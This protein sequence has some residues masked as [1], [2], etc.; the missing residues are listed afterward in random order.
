MEIKRIK[1]QINFYSINDIKF[2]LIRDQFISKKTYNEI[3]K[4]MFKSKN[5]KINSV[6]KKLFLNKKDLKKLLNDGHEIGLH[7]HSHPTKISHLSFKKQFKEYKIN[8][9]YL[10][11]KIDKN[12]NKVISMSHPCGDYNTNTLKILKKME[13]EIGF[14]QMMKKNK[15]FKNYKINQSNFEIAREDHSNI[16]RKFQI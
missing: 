13:I 5:F 16:V 3:M 11:N 8:K 1:K 12:F 9:N 7:S 10:Q 14:R 15:K 2:R 4:K 6:L